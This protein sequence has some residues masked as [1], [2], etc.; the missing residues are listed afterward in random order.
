MENFFSEYQKQAGFFNKLCTLYTLQF[1]PNSL[2]AVVKGW[3]L[4]GVT[5]T[6]FAQ[7]QNLGKLCFYVNKNEFC[8]QNLH[9]NMISFG[10]NQLLQDKDDL[11]ERIQDDSTV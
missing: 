6:S 5:E 4:T 3:K 10:F 7:S 11:Q 1:L 9:G 2:N 8:T